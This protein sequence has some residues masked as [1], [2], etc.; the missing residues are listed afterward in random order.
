MEE[1]KK[2]EKK[3]KKLWRALLTKGCL[4]LAPFTGSLHVMI[5]F[6]SLEEYL[7]VQGSFERF[8]LAW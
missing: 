5:A 6:I 2:R 8:F 1:K 3:K 4:M 7:V